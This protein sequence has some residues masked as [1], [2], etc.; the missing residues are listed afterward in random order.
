MDDESLIEIQ[1]N[2]GND[3]ADEI[4]AASDRAARK[5]ALAEQDELPQGAYAWIVSCEKGGR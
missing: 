1:D 2:A 3:G 4:H 5:Q